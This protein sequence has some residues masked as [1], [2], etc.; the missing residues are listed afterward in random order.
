MKRKFVGQGCL[1][2]DGVAMAADVGPLLR[3]VPLAVFLDMDW[4]GVQELKEERVPHYKDGRRCRVGDFVVGKTYNRPYQMAGIVVD[5]IESE[6]CNA[7]VLPL[8]A[9]LIDRTG[10]ETITKAV[11]ISGHVCDHASCKN[12]LLVDVNGLD[13]S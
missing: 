6:S 11:P 10:A 9:L 5:V 12:L 3:G 8:V 1:G 7:Q 4:V 2:R 13:Q